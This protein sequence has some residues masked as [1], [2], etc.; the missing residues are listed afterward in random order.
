VADKTWTGIVGRLA[1]ASTGL[2]LAL[3]HPAE[4]HP[5]VTADV[6]GALTDAGTRHAPRA[7]TQSRPGGER[8]AQRRGSTRG[9]SAAAHVTSHPK[10]C[11]RQSL[12]L[13]TV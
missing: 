5:A 3:E 11:A 2:V 12:S 4:A 6:V 13:R 8:S 7:R 10:G 1:S 9:A